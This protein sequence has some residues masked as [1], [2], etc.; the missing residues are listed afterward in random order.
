[1][2]ER[3]W[4]LLLLLAALARAAQASGLV[5]I[6][7]T[8]D[9]ITTTVGQSFDITIQVQA[10]NQQVDSVAAFLNFDVSVLQCSSI[11]AGTAL[12]V[13]LQSVIDN[14]A[15]H[16]DVAAGT[17]GANPTGTFTLATVH[18]HA[19]MTSTGSPLTFA[20][21]NPRMTDA[22]L[23]GSS[24]LDHATGGSVIVGSPPTAT[25]SPTA[26]ATPPPGTVLVS[27]TC[28]QPGAAG[29]VA[30]SPGTQVT[31][32]LC[33][34]ASCAV[35]SRVLLDSTI[36]GADG[37]FAFVLD[38]ARIAGQRLVF[39]AAV[40]QNPLTS[41]ASRLNPQGAVGGTYDIIDFGPIAATGQI[42][43]AI[44]PVSE[45]AVRLLE[46]QGIENFTNEGIAQVIS[47]VRTS[48][49]DTSFA[50]LSADGAANAAAETAKSD[51]TVQQTIETTFVCRG[52]CNQS[53]GVL[54]D[55][56]LDMV[57][58][59]LGL[60][61]AS[62]CAAGDANGDGHIAVDEVLLSVD[63]ATSGC[64]QPGT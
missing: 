52:D 30:C 7:T 6:A 41:A 44:D 16:V 34:A 25:A 58:L 10:G 23:S 9:P 13:S 51:P 24:V 64:S 33:V 14:S 17:F 63:R 60:S 26:T 45:A 61:Q 29:L 46:E 28:N 32:S 18:C 54:A 47:Q 31:V 36:V 22:Q 21:V 19:A 43:V 8:P 5:V 12:P 55:E 50:G 40:T 27:G 35:A 39:S 62:T 37:T 15:G 57:S 20:T 53:G 56:I 3:G 4:F 49:A 59:A 48:N 42:N 1:M 11:D 38:G 2:K